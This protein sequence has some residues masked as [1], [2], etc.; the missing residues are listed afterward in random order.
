MI[1]RAAA[2]VAALEVD[3][4]P[5]SDQHVGADL[6]YVRVTAY[7]QDLAESGDREVIVRADG[8]VVFRATPI[9]PSVHAMFREMSRDS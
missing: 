4:C 6:Q 8:Q 9:G 7:A 1:A 3:G 5:F 2:A